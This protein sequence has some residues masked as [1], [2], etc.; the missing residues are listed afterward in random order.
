[1]ADKDPSPIKGV[2]IFNLPCSGGGGHY[3]RVR[4]LCASVF[5]IHI[6]RGLGSPTIFNA[7]STDTASHFSNC[8][9]DTRRHRHIHSDWER[10]G[11]SGC[12]ARSRRCGGAS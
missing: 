12:K 6:K 9:T 7:A 11:F 8:T 4:V 10:T 1:M 5:R 2:E 3:S